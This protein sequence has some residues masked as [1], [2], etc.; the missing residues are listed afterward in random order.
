M[1]TLVGI[2]WPLIEGPLTL[3]SVEVGSHYYAALEESLH[4]PGQAPLPVKHICSLGF[5]FSFLRVEGDQTLLSWMLELLRE[6]SS[7]CQLL[8]IEWLALSTSAATD[9]RKSHRPIPMA[10]SRVPTLSSVTGSWKPE[11]VVEN[12]HCST[13]S[14]RETVLRGKSGLRAFSV[15]KQQRQRTLQSKGA[16]GSTRRN[17]LCFCH[18]SASIFSK[19]RKNLRTWQRPPGRRHENKD[20]GMVIHACNPSTEETIR[21]ITSSRPV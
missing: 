14:S 9:H 20:L 5:R 10:L 16:W 17:T 11:E 7:S 19:E 15:K 13:L 8:N 3:K 4:F 6:Q 21:R 12:S 1:G 2:P 18:Q